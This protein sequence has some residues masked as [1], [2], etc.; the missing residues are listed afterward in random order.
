MADILEM[1]VDINNTW[2]FSDGDLQLVKYN[3]N[4]IQSIQKRLN[5]LYGGLELFY[6]GYGSYL[7]KYV[8]WRRND[9]TLGFM[10]LEILTALSADPRLQNVI[11]SLSYGG[12]GEI[13]GELLIT[14]DDDTDLSV[15][16]V[17]SNNGVELTE[18]TEETEEE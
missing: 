10:E 18:N 5:T 14:I 17:L 12:K 16:M 2:N 9:D 11:V 1:G 13:I 4:I 6:T 8:G 7:M 3:D 15:S